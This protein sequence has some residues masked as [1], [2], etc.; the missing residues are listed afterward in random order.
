MRGEQTPAP[1][2]VSFHP[3]PITPVMPPLR[4][5]RHALLVRLSVGLFHC[6][7]QEGN[8]LHSGDYRCHSDGGDDREGYRAKSLTKI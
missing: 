4:C 1:E 5:V 2:M 6:L 8:T 7:I 3:Y